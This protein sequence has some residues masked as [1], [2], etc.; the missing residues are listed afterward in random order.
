[1]KTKIFHLTGI[2]VFLLFLQPRWNLSAQN[3][4]AAA[5]AAEFQKIKKL[6]EDGDPSYQG[7]LSEIYRRGEFGVDADFD[8]ALKWASI[9]AEKKNPLGIYNLAAIY[10]GGYF[11]ARDFIKADELFK[12]AFDGMKK[13]AETG[14]GRAQFDL[15]CMYAFGLGVEKNKPEALKY[16]KKALENGR[17]K[18]ADIIE[19]LN[20]LEDGSDD[21]TDEE[22]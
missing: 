6:A 15:G 16:L 18:A 5:D 20:D 2:I 14:N 11:D 22:I 12:E 4:K 1:M 19:S 9:S 13:L 21:D 8:L 10:R 3:E 7:E 17:M